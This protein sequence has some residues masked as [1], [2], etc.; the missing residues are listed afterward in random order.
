VSVAYRKP[1]LA[2]YRARHGSRALEEGDNVGHKPVSTELI[3]TV[4]R[5]SWSPTPATLA[6]GYSLGKSRHS[7]NHHTA[8][9][10]IGRFLMALASRLV[11]VEAP[12]NALLQRPSLYMPWHRDLLSWG[13]PQGV[14]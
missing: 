13:G 8:I 12:E 1:A 6:S 5:C 14:R 4:L 11:R 7:G 9:V 3:D 10:P 2:T